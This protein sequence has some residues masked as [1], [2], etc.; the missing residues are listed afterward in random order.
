MATTD[1]AERIEK[2]ADQVV[3]AQSLCRQLLARVAII[4]QAIHDQA[5]PTDAEPGWRRRAA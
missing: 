3:Q 4:E 2:I 5:D 1:T